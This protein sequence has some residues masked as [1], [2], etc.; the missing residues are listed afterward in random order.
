MGTRSRIGMVLPDGNV[1]SIYCHWD[2][3]VSHNGRILSEGYT[4]A[5]KVQELLDLGNL[6]SLNYTVSTDMVGHSFETPIDGICVAYGRD[7]G[8]DDQNAKVSTRKAFYE[9]LDEE[10]NY[11]FE[12]GKWTVNKNDLTEALLEV[13]D[14]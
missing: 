11:L 1:R 12:D 3:Y 7:R 6:S 2:G 5:D 4:I 10:Y 13:E 14:E 8:K 9:D